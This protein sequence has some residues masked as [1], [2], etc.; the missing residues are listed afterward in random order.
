MKPIEYDRVAI[1]SDPA[2]DTQIIE[3]ARKKFFQ[4]RIDNGKIHIKINGLKVFKTM[5]IDGIEL[6]TKRICEDCLMKYGEKIDARKSLLGWW[7]YC[8]Q[9]MRKGL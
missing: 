9:C 4:I 2:R 1:R 5:E 7:Y 3:W 8:P 6:L